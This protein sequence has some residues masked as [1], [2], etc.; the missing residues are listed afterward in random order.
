MCQKLRNDVRLRMLGNKKILRKSQIWV[1][2]QSCAESRLQEFNFSS[3]S[4]KTCKSR[5]Q[6]GVLLS[7]FTR[8]LNFVP[9][10]FRRIIWANKFMVVT[11]PS[12][13]QT[14]IFW[15][16]VYYQS[17]SPIFKE[18]IKQVSCVKIR[19]LTLSCKQYFVYSV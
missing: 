2:A 5:Y 15:R 10:I 16:F 14:L 6:T 18:N 4:Q 7:S 9:N 1:E 11:P 13:L 3:R 8:L 19:N 17:I 12:L